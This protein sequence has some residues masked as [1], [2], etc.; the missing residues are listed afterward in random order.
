MTSNDNIPVF[1][2]PDEM[3]AWTRKLRG[4]GRTIGCVPTMGALHEGHLSLIRA[5]ADDCDETIVTIF[6]NPIQFAPDEDLDQ[7]PRDEANDLDL[8]QANGATAAY[9]P[10]TE[11]MYRENSSVYVVE[12]RLSKSLCGLSRP[13]HFRGVLTIVAKLFNAAIPDRAYFGRKDYQQ[14]L[15]IKQMVRDLD[16]QVEI[17]DCPII[18][19][20]DGLAMSSRNRHL[21]SA[22]RKDALCLKHAL[23]AVTEAFN[24]GERQVRNL[25]WLAR[26]I[27]EPV[28]SSKIDYI[29]CRDAEDLSL[30]KIIEKPALFALAV[31]IGTPRLIDNTVLTPEMEEK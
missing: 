4:Q 18:R 10:S 22:Q 13:M 12:D 17:I 16:F 21:S 29:S 28:N 30:I 20:P 19:E 15:L 1:R 8:A 14:T 3:R 25:E 24:N 23:D 2:T 6:I 5:S 7:Y 11:T 9:C 27:I 26:T 31:F